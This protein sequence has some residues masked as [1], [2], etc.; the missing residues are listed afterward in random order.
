MKRNGFTL[1]EILISLTLVSV[2]L[3]FMLNTLIR[4]KDVYVTS[5]DDTDV[6]VTGAIIARFIN[7]DILENGGIKFGSND[8]TC[9]SS[10]ILTLTTTTCNI[11]LNSGYSRRLVLRLF[12][13]ETSSVI[14]GI[15]VYKV[16]SKSTIDYYDVENDKTLLIKTIES[17]ETYSMTEDAMKYNDEYKKYVFNSITSNIKT[18]FSKT[19]GKT[20]YMRTI[21]IGASK[22]EYNVKIYSAGTQ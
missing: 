10:T 8:V 9:S 11:N 6:R 21:T 3:V 4:L 2:V 16:V 17:T 15:T 20:D 13:N 19:A 12:S 5:N 18:Y 22:S 1:V 7:N 14:D